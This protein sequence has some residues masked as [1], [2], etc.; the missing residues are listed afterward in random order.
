[1]GCGEAALSPSRPGHITTLVNSPV[2]IGI[3]LIRGAEIMSGQKMEERATIL[4]I[5]KMMDLVLL[6]AH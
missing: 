3:M 6:R 5:I 2:R 1:M 4:V